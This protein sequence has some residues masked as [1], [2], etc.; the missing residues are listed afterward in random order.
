ML[1][2]IFLNMFN[3]YVVWTI[4]K[5]IERLFDAS[6]QCYKTNNPTYENAG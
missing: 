1:N 5:F 4:K 6:N 2:I 3:E